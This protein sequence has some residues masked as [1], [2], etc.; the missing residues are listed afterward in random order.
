VRFCLIITAALV[1]G[2]MSAVALASPSLT[3]RYKADLTASAVVPKPG[4]AGG[5]GTVQFA[6]N[7]RRLCWRITVSGID[8]P[9]GARIHSGNA[10]MTGPV[11]V[12]LGR[13]Y[14]HAGCTT[15][16]YEAVSLITGCR[17]GNVYID[18]QTRR[19]PKG[20]VRGVLENAR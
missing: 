4:P 17:C 5:K 9:V 6:L 1:A 18:V 13:H 14:K 20:A 12:R 8:T 2:L 7:G 11:I 10:F 16:S 15:I 19:F 3:R